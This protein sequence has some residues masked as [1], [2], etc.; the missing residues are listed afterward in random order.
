MS[1]LVSVVVP[2]F[3]YA[4]F[5]VECVQSLSGQSY[6]NWECIIVDD[7]SS[8]DTQALGARLCESDTRVRYIRQANAGLS[9]ARNAGLR[10]AH[11]AFVQFL[12]ADD[13]L[14]PEKF[15]VQVQFLLRHGEF[16]GVVGPA[17][18]I[19][20]HQPYAVRPWPTQADVG[21]AAF[22]R[23][24]VCPVNAVLARRELIDSAGRF[25]E[26]LRSH[27]DW[28]FWLRCLLLGKRLGFIA[29]G[30]DR[31]LVRVHESSMSAARAPMLRSAIELREHVHRLLPPEL[32]V[33][34]RAGIAETK[35]RLGL[36]LV[37]E[38][39]G[40][41]GRPLYFE[42]LRES[43]RKSPALLRLPLLL[44]GVGAAVQFGR[45]LLR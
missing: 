35:W 6:Q 42:G 40:T 30:D 28:D 5:L 22:I 11:G 44:P 9:A 26:S 43:D 45:R 25:D 27:E 18:Y 17:A 1:E 33:E 41:E 13:L 32:Q 34:N 37:R 29:Q 12:D 2:C 36:A 20:G 39:N 4:H 8:D 24:N 10:E 14:Q 23:R 16:D 3:N 21:L 19:E 38:G 31:A 15:R 7:G